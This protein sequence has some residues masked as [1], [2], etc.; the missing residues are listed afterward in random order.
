[1]IEIKRKD[2][3]LCDGFRAY[4]SECFKVIIIMLFSFYVK[5]SCSR[6]DGYLVG[7]NNAL[8]YLI[9]CTTVA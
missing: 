9:I 4:G 5:Q 6:C 1:M 2:T 3:I 8:A 7:R